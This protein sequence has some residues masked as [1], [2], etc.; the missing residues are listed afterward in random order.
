M[1]LFRGKLWTESQK[2]NDGNPRAI[3]VACKYWSGNVGDKPTDLVCAVN[4]PDPT[5][6]ESERLRLQTAYTYHNCPDFELIYPYDDCPDFE[7]IRNHQRIGYHQQCPLLH[8]ASDLM[9]AGFI[10]CLSLGE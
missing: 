9:D 2:D 3:C 1:S 10:V 4:T 5:Q 8:S 7:R 6:E